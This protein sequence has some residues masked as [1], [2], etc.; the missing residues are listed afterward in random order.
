MDAIIFV[1]WLSGLS[2]PARINALSRIYLRLTIN[3]RE[4]FVADWTSGKEQRVEEILH[5]L[6]EIHHTLANQ[7]TAYTTD[8]DKAPS[9]ETLSEMLQAIEGKYQLQDFL[10]PAI[11]TARGQDAASP[12]TVY[13]DGRIADGNLRIRIFRERGVDVDS[14]PRLEHIPGI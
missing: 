2:S 3:A 8:R 12:L 1:K 13:P 5:S 7:P 4:L 14:L 11:E 9:V 10:T 6:N